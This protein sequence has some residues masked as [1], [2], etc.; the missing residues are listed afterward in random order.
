MGGTV[1]NKLSLL[2]NLYFIS[3]YTQSRVFCLFFENGICNVLYGWGSQLLIR[4]ELFF[5][6][7]HRACQVWSAKYIDMGSDD[8]FYDSGLFFIRTILYEG[9]LSWISKNWRT[10][11]EP[12]SRNFLSECLLPLVIGFVENSLNAFG[13]GARDKVCPVLAAEEEHDITVQGWQ[14][15]CHRCPHR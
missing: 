8:G 15:I 4:F 3:T 7:R 1:N 11:A 5:L 6:L 14:R 10:L 2:E 13:F 9:N 12:H